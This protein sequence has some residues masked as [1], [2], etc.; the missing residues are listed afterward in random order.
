MA[1]RP[2]GT[3]RPATSASGDKTMVVSD[4]NVHVAS[5]EELK[6]LSGLEFLRRIAD[7]RIPQ[8]P[9]AATLGFRLAEVAPG[10]ALFTMVPEFRHYNPMGGVHGGVACT[11][12]DSTMS[13]AV[14]THLE[15]GFGYTT[16]E[17]KVNFVRPITDKTGPIRAEGR[18]LHVGRRSG[19]AEGKLLDANGTLL[20]HGTTTCL[21]LEL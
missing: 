3:M 8:P 20:A 21:I 1:A 14:Q 13:C 2:F 10:F 5:L 15:K 12:L 7:G 4:T 9:I 19:T 17:L 16:L 18:S 6:G 11:L